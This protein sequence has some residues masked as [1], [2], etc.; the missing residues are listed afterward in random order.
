MEYEITKT[1]L[2]SMLFPSLTPRAIGIEIQAHSLGLA[3]LAPAR[4]K[5]VRLVRTTT[6][7]TTA[8]H[9]L[10]LDP[11]HI[12]ATLKT[13]LTQFQT[14]LRHA[15][16]AVINIPPL[17]TYYERIALPTG[18]ITPLDISI[19]AQEQLNR[20][21]PL[22]AEQRLD[23]WATIPET[24]EL[25]LV[26][27][28]AAWTDLVLSAVLANDLVCVACEPS[29]MALHRVLAPS[30]PT[31]GLA[32]ILTRVDDEFL[33][34]AADARAPVTFFLAGH[35][36]Q[37]IPLH[38]NN[39]LRYIETQYH[40]T[41]TTLILVMPPPE[42][43]DLTNALKQ[44]PLHQQTIPPT[45]LLTGASSTAIPSPVLIGLAQRGLA[46]QTFFRTTS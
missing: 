38:I 22:P 30:L 6:T 31:M 1:V 29:I 27:A 32:I 2:Y 35:E 45:S 44:L 46:R 14:G 43:N 10:L 34:M 21:L 26:G 9:N 28:L 23:G 24:R 20:T 36:A 5:T 3:L 7:S 40:L 33:I 8:E 16:G 11:N 19:F 41:P 18:L 12:A 4:K 39:C 17:H 25:I 37:D 13:A 42:A 15:T